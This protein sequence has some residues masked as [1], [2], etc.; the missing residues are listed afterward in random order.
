MRDSG[1]FT[2]VI[3]I[4]CDENALLNHRNVILPL[5]KKVNSCYISILLFMF[6]NL[7]CLISVDYCCDKVQY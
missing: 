7:S 4:K 5:K 1:N 2:S 6:S 3:N